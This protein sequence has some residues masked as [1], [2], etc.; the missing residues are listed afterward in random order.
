MDGKSKTV[1]I[2]EP[3]IQDSIRR[4]WNYTIGFLKLESHDGYKDANLRGSGVLV[5]A[6]DAH[7]ILTAQHVVKA[8]PKKE[9]IGLVLSNK[10]ETPKLDPTLVKFVEIAK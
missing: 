4:I 3:T 1:N 9:L 8:L 7:A 10:K 2:S 5:K 6:N